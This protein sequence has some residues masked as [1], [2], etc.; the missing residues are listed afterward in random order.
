MSGRHVVFT[1]LAD[2]VDT[3]IDSIEPNSVRRRTQRTLQ[4]LSYQARALRSVHNLADTGFRRADWAIGQQAV[5]AIPILV[6]RVSERATVTAEHVEACV[7]E[8]SELAAQLTAI[9]EGR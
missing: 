3:L 8:A 1:P 6:N 5:I 9:A 4:S 2:A 7:R